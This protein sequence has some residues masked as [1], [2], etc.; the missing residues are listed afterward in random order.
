MPNR[1]QCRQD[2]KHQ[3]EIAEQQRRKPRDQAEPFQEALALRIKTRIFPITFAQNS[4][5]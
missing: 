1:T 3:I 5:R 2:N 4:A